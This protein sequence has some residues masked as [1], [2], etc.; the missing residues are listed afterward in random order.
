MKSEPIEKMLKE[1]LK[2]GNKV[3][4]PKKYLN[5]VVQ[6]DLKSAEFEKP[7]GTQYLQKDIDDAIQR[8]ADAAS[9]IHIQKSLLKLLEADSLTKLNFIESNNFDI[10]FVNPVASRCDKVKVSEQICGPISKVVCSIVC[11]QIGGKEVC[12]RI[13]ETVVDEVCKTIVSWVCQD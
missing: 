1:A 8:Y 11:E 6:A 4:I 5:L 7:L 2:S 12:S 13:C 3:R 9:N 10:S